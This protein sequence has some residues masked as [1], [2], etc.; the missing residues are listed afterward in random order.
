MSQQIDPFALE[1]NRGMA[2]C[3]GLLLFG[4]RL[5]RVF[6]QFPRFGILAHSAEIQ[7]KNS[8]DLAPLLSWAEVCRM[9]RRLGTKPEGSQLLDA[10]K[11]LELMG[12]IM[13]FPGMHASRL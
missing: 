4:L 6:H 1:L 3:N 9:G 13:Y 10:V 7:K 5:F 8:A 11:F 2:Q 12:Y